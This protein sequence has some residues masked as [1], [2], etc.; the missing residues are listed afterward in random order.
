VSKLRPLGLGKGDL[1]T[2]FDTDTELL[3]LIVSGQGSE[4]RIDMYLHEL[5]ERFPPTTV[6]DMICVSRLRLELSIRANGIL[7]ARSAG[8]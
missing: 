1:G 7:L 6:V 4:S 2:G 5:R 3:K 8:F